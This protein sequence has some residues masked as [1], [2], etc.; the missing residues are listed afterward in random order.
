MVTVNFPAFTHNGTGHRTRS[1][2]CEDPRG[3]DS[4]ADHLAPQSLTCLICK[5]R[6]WIILANSSYEFTQPVTR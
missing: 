3:W 2:G 6:G 4:I 5:M 1:W